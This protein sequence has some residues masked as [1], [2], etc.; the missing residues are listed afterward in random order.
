MLP[1]NDSEI[2]LTLLHPSDSSK[3]FMYPLL[4]DI[5]WFHLQKCLHKLVQKLQQVAHMLPMK[6]NPVTPLRNWKPGF[7]HCK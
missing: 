6:R 3:Y 7:A 2:Q 1:V 5:L 4:P